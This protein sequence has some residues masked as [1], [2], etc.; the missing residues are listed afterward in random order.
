MRSSIL[1]RI[2]LIVL[3][4]ALGV[5]TTSVIQ[6][7]TV[8]ANDDDSSATATTVDCAP[9]PVAVNVASTCTATVTAANGKTPTG[10]VLFTATSSGGALLATATCTLVA[11]SCS[12]AFTSGTPDTVTITATYMPDTD[13]FGG[14]AGATLLTVTAEDED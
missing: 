14:S 7:A 8:L 10:T 1:G 12:V 9:N 6:P 4:V 11:G 2:A 13:E 5:A 3:A